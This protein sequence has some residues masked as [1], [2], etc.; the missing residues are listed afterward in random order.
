MTL[1]NLPVISRQTAEAK[2]KVDLGGFVQRFMENPDGTSQEVLNAVLELDRVNPHLVS[3]MG[4][5]IEVW[6]DCYKENF[7]QVDFN[8]LKIF[9]FKGILLLMDAINS[10]IQITNN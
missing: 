6:I 5:A 8:R 7:H 9:L 4:A 3:L 2:L 10:E 1:D